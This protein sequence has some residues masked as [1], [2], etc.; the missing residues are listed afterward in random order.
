MKWNPCAVCF[1]ADVSHELRTPLTA[2]QGSLEGLVDGV[3]PGTQETYLQIHAEAQRLNRLVNDLQEL[4]RVESHAFELE[5]HTVDVAGLMRTVLK[6][7]SPVAA[8]HGLELKSQPL[9]VLP[10]LQG[11]EDR[12]LQVVSNIVANA[13]NYTPE[14]G[15]VTLS[16]RRVADEVQLAVRDT[17]VGIAAEHLPRI[18]D[19]FYRIDKS[20][21]RQAGGSGIGLTVA[22]A[23]VE[24]HGGRIW[25]ES[26]GPGRGSTFT[27][28]STAPQVASSTAVAAE[29]EL[30][31]VPV[32]SRQAN[33]NRQF[34]ALSVA[35]HV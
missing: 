24:A 7:M 19:R 11:D 20:R 13:L 16:A 12:L 26:E 33:P 5:R 30:V 10:P 17:G 15:T 18:F 1:I 21:S 4:S 22:R 27:V 8:A 35:W 23:L 9:P 25:A 31:R 29:A 2:I 28:A 32:R 14:G 6:R 3:L 34:P